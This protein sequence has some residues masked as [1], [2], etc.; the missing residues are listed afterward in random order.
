LWAEARLKADRFIQ[1]MTDDGILPPIVIPDTDEA[2]G[3]AALTEAC[4]LALGPTDKQVKLAAIRTVLEYTKA[5]PE[6]KS[7]LTLST[8][9]QWL[10]EIAALEHDSAK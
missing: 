8:S 3:I 4:V 5:K 2:K 10:A 1:K 9:E 6:S 7:K